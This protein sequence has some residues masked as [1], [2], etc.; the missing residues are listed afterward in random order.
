MAKRTR[1]IKRDGSRE[2]FDPAKLR[3]S[4]QSAAR[5]AGIPEGRRGTIEKS[6][7][8]EVQEKF[9][10]ALEIRAVDLR[11]LILG[12]LDATE[13]KAARSWRDHDREAKGLA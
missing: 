7:V 8:G 6:I 9:G 11:E 1:V 10:D 5:E 13:P 2:R 12:H 4:L 3:R